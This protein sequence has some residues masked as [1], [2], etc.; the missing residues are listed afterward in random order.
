[1]KNIVLVLS[2]MSIACFCGCEKHPFESGDV[3]LSNS[4]AVSFEVA[5]PADTA[6]P[7]EDAPPAE[8]NSTSEPITVN[9]E[10]M[11]EDSEEL[12][13]DFSN[14]NP[15]KYTIKFMESTDYLNFPVVSH[16][17]WSTSAFDQPLE[18]WS[19]SNVNNI[20]YMFL[21]A[22]TFKLSLEKW[23]VSNVTNDIM[24]HMFY[25]NKSFHQPLNQR[26][27]S[28]DDHRG[29]IIREALSFNHWVLRYVKYSE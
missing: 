26:N 12:S 18:K 17:F 25:N 3:A 6:L 23:D 5:P 1:M 20:E 10:Q 15:F 8:A 9:E 19:V 22:D 7:T 28:S 27:I 16:M 11:A 29:R 14:R 4:G 13:T 2:V 21:R 24:E